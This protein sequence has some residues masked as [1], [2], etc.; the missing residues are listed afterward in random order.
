MEMTY[1]G[2]LTMPANFAALDAEEMTYVEGGY[3]EYYFRTKYD[4]RDFLA[5]RACMCLDYMGMVTILGAASASNV[6]IALT[7]GIADY[8]V[9][10]WRE[11][12]A[13]AAHTANHLSWTN[14]VK[15]TLEI[16]NALMWDINFYKF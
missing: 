10:Q 4:A 8:L 2:T 13:T 1:N 15:V 7:A 16:N 14:N 3:N 5:N 9:A 11:Q 6:L 12:Y